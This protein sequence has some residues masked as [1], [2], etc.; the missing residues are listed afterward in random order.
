LA[1]LSAAALSCCTALSP[2]MLQ[3]RPI[4]W[5]LAPGTHNPFG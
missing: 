1:F 4:S 5:N 3:W 2:D